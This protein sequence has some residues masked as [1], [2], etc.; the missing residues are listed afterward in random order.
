M[1]YK[2]F[3][4]LDITT[5]GIIHKSGGPLQLADGNPQ[6]IAQLLMIWYSEELKRPELGWSTGFA[7]DG[8][9]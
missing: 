5:F 2:L 7:H 3:Y 9:W 1:I 6:H 8:M 4:L